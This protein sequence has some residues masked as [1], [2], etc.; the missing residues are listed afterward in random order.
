MADG[1]CVS[2]RPRT[3][4][5]GRRGAALP[6]RATGSA[7]WGRS[8]GGRSGMETP[9]PFCLLLRRPRPAAG[10][11]RGVACGGLRT[12]GGSAESPSVRDP[13]GGSGAALSCRPVKPHF[14]AVK[15]AFLR[16][17]I[18]P[19]ISFKSPCLSNTISSR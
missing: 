17:S 1:G 3:P 16:S 10:A 14:N 8:L 2:P 18:S 7:P 4:L 9:L 11:G 12:S 5:P 15:I 13:G 6:S 19:Q